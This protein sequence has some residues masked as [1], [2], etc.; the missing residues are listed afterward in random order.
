MNGFIK[1]HRQL[2]DDP[3]WSQVPTPWFRV[4]LAMLMTANWKPRKWFDGRQEIT[5]PPGSLVTS[6]PSM[7]KLARVTP[8]QYRDA[9][10]YLSRTEFCNQQTTNR[11]TV[12]TITS[13]ATYQG[14]ESE[15]NQ[16]T[17]RKEPTENQQRTTPEEGKKSSS[18]KDKK[19][20]PVFVSEEVGVQ[21]QGKNPEGLSKIHDDDQKPQP[22]SERK[23]AS[24]T[25]ELIAVIREATGERPDRKLLRQI[26]DAVEGRGGTLRAYLDDIRPRI[27]RLKR[28]PGLGFFYTHGQNWG[29]AEQRQAPEPQQQ[30]PKCSCTFGQ[31]EVD[32]EWRPCPEC[33]LGRDL[34]AVS[35]RLAKERAAKEAAA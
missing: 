16:Q 33:K 18:K 21:P 19:K 29:G 35:A 2:L 12:V 25:D 15:E 24:D 11:Y 8:Q 30:A 23:W 22:L 17:T 34:A 9:L 28:K 10:G 14:V 26:S 31:I 3:L 1:L 13:W 32:G 5:L 4:A 6:R 27:G 7:C 20:E